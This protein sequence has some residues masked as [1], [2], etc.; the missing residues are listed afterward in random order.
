MGLSV[1]REVAESRESN[2]LETIRARQ[3][4]WI[5][6]CSKQNI[7]DPC[8]PQQGWEQLMAIY[9]KY[10]MTGVNFNAMQNVRSKTVRGYV[11]A[12]AELFTL[13]NF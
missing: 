7:E 1:A 10:V 2:E 6:W 4:F 11:L 5:E 13:R 3:A 12:A 8:G 9:A